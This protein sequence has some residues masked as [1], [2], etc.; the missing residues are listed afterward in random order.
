MITELE[1]VS[2]QNQEISSSQHSE[3]SSIDLIQLQRNLYSIDSQVS[4]KAAFNLTN[5]TATSVLVLSDALRENTLHISV[6]AARAL[7]IMGEKATAAVESLIW[8]LGQDSPE[9]RSGAAAALGRIATEHSLVVPA[10]ARALSDKELPVRQYAAAAL[11]SYGEFCVLAKKQLKTA[12]KDEDENV[13]EFSQFAL[14]MIEKNRRGKKGFSFGLN[15]IKD[16]IF[17]CV[18]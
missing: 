11:G 5:H 17:R 6:N 3:V 7:G 12:M 16:N 14:A 4:W 10:L 8:A 1:A 9:L 15:Q 2:K 18:A 13:R